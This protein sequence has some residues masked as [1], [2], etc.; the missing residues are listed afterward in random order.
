M[1]ITNNIWR[2][3]CLPPRIFGTWL[4]LVAILGRCQLPAEPGGGRG[5]R[6]SAEMVAKE[7][8]V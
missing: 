8:D 3:I 5:K 7:A 2:A 4:L 1:G 6:K